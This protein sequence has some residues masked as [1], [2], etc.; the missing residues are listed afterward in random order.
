MK[1]RATRVMVAISAS[2]KRVF[3]NSIRVLP[4][5]LRDFA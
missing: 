2:L 1:V 3:W 5:A 4:K